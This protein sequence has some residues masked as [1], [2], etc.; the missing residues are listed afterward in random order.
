MTPH[1][2]C[3][4]RGALVTLGALLLAMT[5][6]GCARPQPAR[7]LDFS[8]LSTAA[9]TPP[10]T[11]DLIVAP[12]LPP[13]TPDPPH[14][15]GVADLLA[16]RPADGQTV[17]VDAY[18]SAAGAPTWP[19][20]GPPPPSDQVW[21]PQPWPYTLTDRPY[22]VALAYLNGM[23][24]NNPPG[25][26]PWLIAA[27]LE[28]TQPNT[29]SLPALPYHA[30]L[31]GHLG[32]PAFAGLN[33]QDGDHIF[34]VERVVTVYQQDPP[35]PAAVQLTVPTD[36]AAWLRYSDPAQGYSVPYP[37]DWKAELLDD[38]TLALRG[39]QWPRHPVLVRIQE[40]EL[41]YDQYDPANTPPLL[42][43]ADGWGQFQQGGWPYDQLS[44]RPQG[45]TGFQ[46]QRKAG[47]TEGE[48]PV[49]VL[50]GGRNRTYE[51]SLAYPTGFAASPGLT[52]DYTA[53]VQGFRL[54]ELPGP[55]ATPPIRQELGP[56]PFLTEEQA[57]AKARERS[58]SPIENGGGELMSEAA[59]R[60]LVTNS[61]CNTFTGHP[62]GV[63]VLRVSGQF[64]GRAMQLRLLLDAVT[65]EQ[66]CGEEIAAE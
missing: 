5:L 45:L 18:F 14:A 9:V 59:A 8:P 46:V 66:L 4:P 54:D 62:E 60:Q 1:A 61:P 15:P 17:E 40:G 6:T 37:P 11:P 41:N 55:T 34:V 10:G 12:T 32:D 50:F 39:P 58:E 13:F 16:T 53:I 64:E 35:N 26:T 29:R 3:A 63:W 57:F 21:C 51:I 33:C 38:A 43:D 27:I 25:D 44:P 48:R 24:G 28:Q 30:R 22:P 2:S 56:G 20:G 47:A 19:G 23:T 36:Y 65:G 52:R 42:R 31:A 49:A 7:A